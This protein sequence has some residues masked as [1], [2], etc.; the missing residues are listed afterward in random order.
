VYYNYTLSI[1]RNEVANGPGEHN[2][3]RYAGETEMS[4]SVIV[5]WLTITVLVAVPILLTIASGI[6]MPAYL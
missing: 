1:N 5:K 4:T 3:T 6:P 2:D